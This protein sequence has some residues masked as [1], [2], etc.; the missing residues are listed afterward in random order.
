MEN[1]GVSYR[2]RAVPLLF[3]TQRQYQGSLTQIYLNTGQKDLWHRRQEASVHFLS[4]Q[5]MT[6]NALTQLKCKWGNCF[7]PVAQLS[8]FQPAL[9]EVET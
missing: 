6:L 8:M 3:Q 2:Q 7:N 9:T 5:E 1:K 4:T